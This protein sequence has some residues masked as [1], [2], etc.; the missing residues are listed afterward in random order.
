M[1]S[2][3]LP[4]LFTDELPVTQDAE[5]VIPPKL[6]DETLQQGDAFTLAGIALFVQHQ[7]VH[8][9]RRPFIH[10]T[11]GQDVKVGFA[12]LPVCPVEGQVVFSSGEAEKTHLQPGDGIIIKP[13]AGKE[14]LQAAVARTG[15]SIA[16]KCQCQLRQVDLLETEQPQQQANKTIKP[17]L[18]PPLCQP[19]L[20]PA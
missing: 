12:P 6:A 15:V 14:P 10:N 18:A 9:D 19:C 16:G 3:P 11:Q 4:P 13:H 1:P 2:Q 5:D 20:E 7:P 17:G 8:R